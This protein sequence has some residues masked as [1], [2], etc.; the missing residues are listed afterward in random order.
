VQLDK[1]FGCMLMLFG[2]DFIAE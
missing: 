1:I 2:C